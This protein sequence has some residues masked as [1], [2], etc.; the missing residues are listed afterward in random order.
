[1]I[2]QNEKYLKERWEEFWAMK[3]HDRPILSV[4]A[5]VDKPDYSAYPEY[6]ENDRERWLNA[7]YA[8]KTARINMENTFY[9]GEAFPA[10]NPNLGPDLLGAI[11]GCDIEF[12]KDT[13]WAVPNL[14]NLSERPQSEFNEN[15]FYWK[16]IKEITEKAVKD[17]KGDYLVGITDLHPGC[18][19]IVSLRGS[20]ELCMDL[21]DAPDNINLIQHDI[22]EVHKTVIEK[23]SNIISENQSGSTNWMGIWHPSKNWYVTSCDFSCL[24]SDSD[25]DKYVLPSLKSELEYLDAS[26]YHLDG[27]GALRHIDKL[28]ALDNLHGIQWVYGAGATTAKDWTELMKKIQDAGKAIQVYCNPQ[29]ADDVCSALRPEGLNLVCNLGSRS[30]AIEFIKHI[31]RIYKNK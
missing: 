8:I 19:G 16:K 14:E 28:L 10:F 27:P 11:C 5:P 29:D 4:Y 23:L 13:S 24:I 21:F 6:I 25:F 2:N 31:E 20:Q 9:G 17:S 18:D 30:D 22:F 15:N 12:G 1:M 3:N 26:M 7:D